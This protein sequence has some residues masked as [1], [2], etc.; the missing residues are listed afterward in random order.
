MTMQ[1]YFNIHTSISIIQKI[2]RIKDR[3]HT[4][5]SKDAEKLLTKFNILS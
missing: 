4:I 3:K 2:S 5:I 1:G